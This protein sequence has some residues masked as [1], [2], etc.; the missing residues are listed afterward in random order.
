[1]NAAQDI[2]K[3]VSATGARF[4]LV[5]GGVGFDKPLLPHLLLLAK[6]H[7]AEIKTELEQQWDTEWLEAVEERAGIM[8][9]MGGLSRSDAEQQAMIVCTEEFRRRSSGH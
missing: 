8:E 9:H 6:Q 1:M 7:K 3:Q 4:M 2:I 5:N